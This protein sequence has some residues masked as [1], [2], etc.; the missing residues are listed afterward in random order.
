M[1]S[2]IEEDCDMLSRE[3]VLDKLCPGGSYSTLGC[4]LNVAEATMLLNKLS[5]DRSTQKTWL[6]LDN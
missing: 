1:S 3:N 6:H 5:I 4:E 2:L